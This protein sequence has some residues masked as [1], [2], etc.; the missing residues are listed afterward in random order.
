MADEIKQQL[1]FD[2][3]QT[4]SVLA[5]LNEAFAKFGEAIN[6][7]AA[8]MD[9][10]NKAGAEVDTGVKKTS[11]VMREAARIFEQTRTPLERYENTLTKL[12]GLLQQGAINQNTYNRAMKQAGEALSGAQ[13]TVELAREGARI[14]EQ[15][16]TPQEKYANTSARLNTLLQ[17]G[18]INQDTH[19]RALKRAQE[20]LDGTCKNANG[21]AVSWN[22][23]A[24]VVATQFIVRAMSMIRDAFKEAYTS[25]LEFSNQVSEIHAISPERSFGAIATEARR[26]S[27]AFNQPLSRTIEAEYQVISDQFVSTTARLNIMTA[28]NALAKVGADDLVSSAQLLTGA[29]NAYGESSDMAGIR[30]AQFFSVRQFGSFSHE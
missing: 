9:A 21:L 10:F 3:S 19:T 15:T 5:Q 28:A 14:Y 22:T 7:A 30:A 26:L 13:K 6:G 4:F 11:A 18:A 2:A 24:R 29:L 1:G 16:R 27:D 12:N 17:Q 23:L 20:A 8:R 25:A